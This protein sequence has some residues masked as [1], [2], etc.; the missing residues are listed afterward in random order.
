MIKAQGIAP[1]IPTKNVS[2]ASGS[3]FEEGWSGGDRIKRFI[4]VWNLPVSIGSAW[5]VLLMMVRLKQANLPFQELNV[6]DS[7]F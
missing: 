3:G 5:L 6:T 1:G 4:A 7:F 2:E